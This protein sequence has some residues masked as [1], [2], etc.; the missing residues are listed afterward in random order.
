[1][2]ILLRPFGA[3]DRD[4]NRS[5]LRDVVTLDARRYVVA[6]TYRLGTL[7]EA[8]FGTLLNQCKAATALG[9]EIGRARS[10]GQERRGAGHE[11]KTW[12]VEAGGSSLWPNTNDVSKRSRHHRAGKHRR[13][14]R[15]HHAVNRER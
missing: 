10:V 13:Q 3:E 14:R 6:Q 11:N 9:E 15:Q 7:G 12:F 4:R 5:S 2:D 8:A 1:M